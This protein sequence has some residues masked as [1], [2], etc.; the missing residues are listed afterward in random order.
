V[1]A[2]R[3]RSK[4]APPPD[5]LTPGDPDVDRG[6]EG[7]EAVPKGAMGVGP[8][9]MAAEERGET[10]DEVREREEKV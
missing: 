5:D 9:I 8:D 7:E 6:A 2:S 10:G 3:S 1:M 4:S